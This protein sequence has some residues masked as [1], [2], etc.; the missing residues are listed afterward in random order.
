M[1]YLRQ[2]LNFEVEVATGRL[3]ADELRG[4]VQ[5]FDERYTAIYGPG[6]AAP[7]SGYTL[8]SYKVLGVG[9]LERG[10]AAGPGDAPAGRAALKGTRRALADVETGAMAD[11]DVYDG[12]ALA[13]GSSVSGPVIVEYA[14]TTVLVPAASRA[15]VDAHGN[16]HLEV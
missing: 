10:S 11:V 13:P 6:P 7:E 9:R 16:L 4:V 1:S 5:T 2:V 8:K 3:T 14:D 12:A 15:S